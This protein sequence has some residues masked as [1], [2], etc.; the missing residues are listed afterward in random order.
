MCVER[1][2]YNFQDYV[3]TPPTHTI[4]V[5]TGSARLG[6]ASMG[7]LLVEE[8]LDPAAFRR[9]VKKVLAVRTEPLPPAPAPA[10]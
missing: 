8:L 10:E 7:R 6:L 1:P 2:Q 9:D 3:Y 5:E 4:V